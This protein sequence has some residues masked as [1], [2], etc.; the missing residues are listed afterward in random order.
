MLGGLPDILRMRE[1]VVPPPPYWPP[2]R[3]GPQGGPAQGVENKMDGL[4]I[5]TAALA[6][7]T[8]LLV[9]VG[10]WQA[11]A[12]RKESR[13]ERTLVACNRYEADV[14]VERCVRRL[15]SARTNERF[16]ANPRAYQQT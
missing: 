5:A 3:A 10:A 9:A 12:I 16:A 8:F 14:V 4:T 15:R 2:G 13:L 1:D 6:A 7:I 11:L